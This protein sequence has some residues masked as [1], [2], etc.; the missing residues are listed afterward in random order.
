MGQRAGRPGG[1][2][3]VGAAPPVADQLGRGDV[4]RRRID[5]R[6]THAAPAHRQRAAALVDCCTCRR[7]L[8]PGLA[9]HRR[10]RR[11][12][13]GRGGHRRGQPTRIHRRGRRRAD[14]DLDR[15]RLRGG[16]GG[17]AALHPGSSPADSAHQHRGGTRPRGP[18][19]RGRAAPAR[20]PR[21][22]RLRGPCHDRRLPARSRCA[23]PPRRPGAD[24]GFPCDH[25]GDRPGRHGRAPA[26]PRRTGPRRGLDSR[27]IPGEHRTVAKSPLGTSVARSGRSRR[28][29]P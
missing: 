26:G 5:E 20:R 28:P 3:P 7:R 22:A 15:T 23:N 1:R 25:R 2:S 14:T 27:G 21:P 4:R 24:P 17:R 9:A 19:R 10:P 6:D 18:P 16:D 11:G 8:H 13:A 12:G 29:S